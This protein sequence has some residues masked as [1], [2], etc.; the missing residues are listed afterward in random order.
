MIEKT[1]INSTA[2]AATELVE[3]K[4]IITKT[5]IHNNKPNMI[6]LILKVNIDLTNTPYT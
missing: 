6:Y 4:Q 5:I 3:L 2:I 1:E